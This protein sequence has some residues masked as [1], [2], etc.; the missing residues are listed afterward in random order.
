MTFADGRLR[1]EVEQIYP[2][3]S[4]L[5]ALTKVQTRHARGKIV[6]SLPERA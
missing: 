4:A 2:F 3:D 1:L 5:E 6:L